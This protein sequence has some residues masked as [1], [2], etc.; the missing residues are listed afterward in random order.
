MIMGNTVIDRN[1]NKFHVW[2]IQWFQEITN[3]LFSSTYE[4]L[5]NNTLGQ[6]HKMLGGN[7]DNL[8]SILSR[9]G[10]VVLAL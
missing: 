7:S 2:Q 6:N 9:M 10:T 4:E 8:V 5:T 3:L 1:N